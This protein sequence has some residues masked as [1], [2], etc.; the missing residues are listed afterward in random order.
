MY[1]EVAAL[2][3]LL[4]IVLGYLAVSRLYHAARRQRRRTEAEAFRRDGDS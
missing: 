1:H 2:I 4:A 3:G